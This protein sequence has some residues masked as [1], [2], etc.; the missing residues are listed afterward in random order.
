MDVQRLKDSFARVA[1]HGDA[2]PLFFYSDLFLRH[3]ETRDLFPVSM[4]AQRDRLVHALGRIVSDVDRLDDLRP[5]VQ[6]LGREHRKFGAVADHYPA[7]G[8]S[9]LA[10]LAHFNGPAWTPELATDWQTAYELV[11][12][13]MIEAAA[14]D[15]TVR[16]AFWEGTV[17]AHEL[18]RFDIATF[19]VATSEPLD[20]LPGQSVS[21][22]SPERPRI[23]RFYSMA[24]APRDD[25]TMDFHVRMLDGGTLSM[26]LTRG[27]AVGARLKIGPPVGALT[28]EPGSGRD[29]LLAAGSTGLAPLKAIAEQI[30]GLPDPPR[31]H[32]FFGARTADGLY[33]LADLEKMAAGCR[34][35][36][37]VP[38]VSDEPGFPG[39]RGPLHDVLARSG[40]WCGHDVYAS[41]PTPMVEA[42]VT[43]LMALGVPRG[44]IHLEDFGWSEP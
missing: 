15:A 25:L 38:V 35:L 9:L 27:L 28:Y 2:V 31:V 36:T 29:V 1:M 43:Q 40:N 8:A 18:R 22:E 3:P 6:D 23:W 14:D 42:T 13:V 11:A 41:G 37:V 39:E 17:V 5:F 33:D 16:P 19:R 12:Q 26:V 7:V 30:A 4:A 10:T 34:W 44:Q 32:L 20:Y 24:N 21:M